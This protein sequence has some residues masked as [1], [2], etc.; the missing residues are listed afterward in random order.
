MRLSCLSLPCCFTA[1]LAASPKWGTGM[2][3]SMRRAMSIRSRS[4]NGSA[5]SACGAATTLYPYFAPK[6]TAA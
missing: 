5:R 3:R 1:A 4:P 6:L 2:G